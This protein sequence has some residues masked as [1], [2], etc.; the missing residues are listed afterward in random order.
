MKKGEVEFTSLDRWAEILDKSELEKISNNKTLKRLTLKSSCAYNKPFL[1]FLAEN[2]EMIFLEE[3][4]LAVLGAEEE[5]CR[6][7]GIF[8]S[9]N[10]FLSKFLFQPNV[11]M[12]GKPE[13]LRHVFEGLDKHSC[14][15]LPCRRRRS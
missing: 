15:S 7:L 3:L 1:K 14:C 10:T 8:L 13:A 9:S 2:G 4:D 5:G 12:N 6:H 11:N